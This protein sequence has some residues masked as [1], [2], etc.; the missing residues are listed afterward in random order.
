MLTTL[1]GVRSEL[2][3]ILKPL[4]IFAGCTR[5][6]AV[7][8]SAYSLLSS[9]AAP[10]GCGALEL[11]QHCASKPGSGLSK[12]CAWRSWPVHA[13]PTGNRFRGLRV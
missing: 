2:R 6:R 9:S 4:S 1:R 12:G 10:A 8:T 11:L 13:V 5:T 3:V 7:H